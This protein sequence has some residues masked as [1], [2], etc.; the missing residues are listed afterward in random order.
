LNGESLIEFPESNKTEDFIA[1]LRRIREANEKRIVVWTISGR[2][3]L[4]R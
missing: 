1:F 4:R 2:I 3:M